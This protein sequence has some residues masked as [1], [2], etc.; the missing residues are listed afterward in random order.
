MEFIETPIQ[1]I[2][3]RKGGKD[4]VKMSK[5]K[6]NDTPVKVYQKTR[7]EHV[8]DVMIA[9][10]VAGIIA[11]IAGMHF[12]NKQNAKVS[13]AVNAVTL[14]QSAEAAPAKK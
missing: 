3:T 4:I 10:L 1:K 7:G 11:F 8:K 2:N 14:T 5:Q 6:T 12:A 9:I 13:E